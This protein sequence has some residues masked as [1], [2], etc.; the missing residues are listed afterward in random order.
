MKSFL[1]ISY[2]CLFLAIFFCSKLHAATQPNV[3]LIY[4]DDLG[5]SDLESYGNQFY[6][7]PNIDSLIRSGLRFTQA[8]SSA[9]LCAPSRIALLTGR[10]NARAGSYEVVQGRYLNQVD[11]TKEAFEPPQNNINL[12]RDRK[13]IPEY[14]KE[15][16]YYTGFFG[17][18]HV[19]SQKPTERGFDDYVEVININSGGSH[20]DVSTAF[21]GKT[22][23]YPEAQGFSGDYLTECALTFLDRAKEKPFFMY[24]SH[25]LVHIPIEAKP[26]LIK[27]YEAKTPTVYHFNATYAAMMETLDNNIGTL[28]ESLKEHGLYDNTLIIFTSDN[29]GMTANVKARPGSNGYK[30]GFPTS[31]YPIRGGKCQL[32]EGGIRIPMGI[33]LGD[34]IPSELFEGPTSQLDLLPTLLDI[35][36]YDLSSQER[37]E[38]DGRTLSTHLQNPQSSW[39]ERSIFWHYPGFRGVVRGPWIDEDAEPGFDQRPASAIRRGDWKLI[40]SLE[41]GDAQLFHLGRDSGEL[42]DIA[43]KHP[44]IVASLKRELREWREEVNAPKLIPRI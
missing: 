31:N 5:Y 35:C 22:E 13:I 41:T 36:G 12:P 25:T 20:L 26:D 38:L 3:V 8:Y 39:P 4:I 37:G 19:G 7:T 24:L 9:P 27:K 2:S 30:I 40:E 32:Y 43:A 29:G 15:I 28:V 18:W 21:K 42:H 11:L 6:E 16:G 23:G 1:S 14:L 33:V 34:Q 44:D 10:H 17:K